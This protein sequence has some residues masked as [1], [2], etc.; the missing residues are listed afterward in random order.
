MLAQNS[1]FDYVR[2]AC[3]AAMSIHATN[4]DVSICLI[5]NESVPTK[6]KHLFV[7]KNN[8]Y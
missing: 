6:Y 1:G 2:Q 4:K 8:R 3:L 7:L 5:T